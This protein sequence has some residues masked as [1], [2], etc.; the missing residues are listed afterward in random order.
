LS[1]KNKLLRISELASKAGV[2][3]R[4]I[5]FYVQEGLLPQPIK[6]GKTMAYYPDDFV[7]KIRAIRSAQAKRFLPLVIIKR[8]LEQ[9]NFDYSVLSDG[10][11]RSTQRKI[12]PPTKP[13]YEHLDR[14]PLNALMHQSNLTQRILKDMTRKGWINPIEEKGKQTIDEWEYE[15]LRMF[16]DLCK[17]GL[18]WHEF[19]SHF[20]A[21]QEIVEKGIQVEFR[22]LFK[23]IVTKPVKDIERIIELEE[24]TTGE[25][26]KR[27]RKNSF[28]KAIQA[29][30][31][32]ADYAYLA[33]ADEGFVIPEDEIIG[34]L[35]DLQAR[36]EIKHPD[37]REMVDLATGYSCIG[38]LDHSVKI[39]RRVIKL[40]P[41]NL[42]AKV[43]LIWYR[44]YAKR[45]I[46]QTKLES[47]LQDI[48]ARNP[49][50]GLGHAFLA[51]WYAFKIL[52]MEKSKEILHCLNLCLNEISQ[53]E[54]WRSRDL[55][56]WVII[57]YIKG[58]IY[59]TMPA[60]GEYLPKK[61]QPFKEI[62]NHK[63]EID[64]YY[65]AR[66]P[67]FPKWLWPNVY[68][69]YGSALL[70]QSRF[71]EA[72]KILGYGLNYNAS[73]PYSER[74]KKAI[75]EAKKSIHERGHS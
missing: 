18:S 59:F 53:A 63:K 47:Q 13:K 72:L 66:M 44:R 32:T 28:W 7:E 55:H 14:Y 4:T 21:I 50:Y 3:P 37:L 67:F 2:T 51:A 74:L 5:R 26:I 36:L 46:E 39:L 35:E 1:R 11:H 23:W 34:E 17:N 41:D 15:F 9:S 12:Q 42:D 20:T 29:Y 56:D 68:Y 49:G 40:D 58:R 25:F 43:R 6:T 54:K 71:K 60:L 70:Q 69:F 61:A 27:I 8:M 62:L 30:T 38:A 24:K 10:G 75:S 52:G 22:N 45:K 64:K 16:L 48:V 73:S 33:T 19:A 31:S 57:K 65:E